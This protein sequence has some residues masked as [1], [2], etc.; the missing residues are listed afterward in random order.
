MKYSYITTAIAYVNGAPH[1]GFALESIQADA[2]ARFWRQQGKQVFFL[3]GTDEHGAKVAKTAEELGKSPQE[4]ADENS[5]KFKQLKEKLNLS[6]DDFIRTTDRKNHWPNVEKIWKKL[7]ANGDIYKKK[8]R[9]LYCVGHEAFVTEKDL[10]NGLCR[11]HK[12]KPTVIEEENYFFRLSKYADQVKNAIKNGEIKIYPQSRANEI[13]SFIN[14]GIEDISFSRPRKDLQ[15]GIPVPGDSQQTI[16]VWADALTNYLYPEWSLNKKTWPADLHVI[17]KDILRFHALYWP[18]M[19]IATGLAVPRAIFA[20]GFIT[21]EGQKMSKTL[22]NVVD[23][24]GLAD[25]YGT[26]A[27][28]YY[29]LREIPPFQDGDFSTTK[30]KA[31]YNSD[32]ANDLG[33]L[34]ARVGKMA[35]NYKVGLDVQQAKNPQV[36][37]FINLAQ[38]A[39]D[40]K[41][42]EYKLNEA[43]AA[44]WELVRFGNGYL[45]NRKPWQTGDKLV[46]QDAA[47]ILQTLGRL[48]QPFLPDT[49][50]KIKSYQI[51]N[52]FPRLQ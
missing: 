16:Y 51:N 7:A 52:L 9:G 50:E 39:V 1:I 8:Y 6:W 43:L 31:R 45:N 28:R 4:L 10:E 37:E 21:V 25:N 46:I 14:E 42:E 19:L 48:L 17:G 24:V 20:H 33:N 38:K 29:L 41:M 35:Q 36:V 26:D 40:Q 18:A 5:A 34:A 27:L 23:P 3:T 30:F 12:A 2:I 49:A 22:G 15:W 32:L 11:D 44:I 47:V 13:L